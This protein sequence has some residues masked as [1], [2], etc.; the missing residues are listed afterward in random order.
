MIER[1]YLKD[2]LSFDEVDLSFKNGLVVFSGAS[3]SGKSVLFESILATCGL[4]DAR[5]SLSEI[6]ISSSIDLDEYGID[7]SSETI[8][9]QTKKEKNRFFINSQSV[10][11]STLKEISSKYI[12]FLNLKDYSDFTNDSLIQLLD[13]ISKSNSSEF[14]KLLDEY[15]ASIKKVIKL[16]KELKKIEDEESKVMDLKDFLLFEIEKIEAISPEL[17]EYEELLEI[18]K[19]LSKKEKVEALLSQSFG[20]FEYESVVSMTLNDSD[21]DSSFFDDTMNELRSQFENISYSFSE[22][23][24]Y[25]IEAILTR[26]EELSALKRKYGSIELALKARDEKT[27]ELQRLDN[28]SFEKENIIND[29]KFLSIVVDDL[30]KSIT[31][32]REKSSIILE[33]K[34]NEYIELLF[35]D[36]VTVSIY[37]K[38]PTMSGKDGVS[39]LLDNI[40]IKDISS[41]E[42]N[43]L[44]LALISARSDFESSSGILILDEIDANLSGLESESIAK[45][46]KRLSLNYQIFSISHQPQLTS[47]ADQHFVVYKD[48]DKSYVKELT[49]KNQ[50]VDEIARMISGTNITDKA[51]KFA[52]EIL[53]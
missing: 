19:K 46:L 16:Q 36:N 53:K 49:T 2:N 42:F 30:A 6:V 9:R 4:K 17:G 41:G 12:N 48:K 13:T 33:K 34:I 1:F 5:S 45:V 28:L 18:K 44:R 8:F 50:R 51:K 31:I 27:Q 22:L 15:Q 47:S 38:E 21:I 26:L 29:L 52:K 37:E 43:R 10:S 14:E 23:D 35:L 20:I 40:S 39:I 11:K 25:D 24:D 7:S 3:G 32:Y